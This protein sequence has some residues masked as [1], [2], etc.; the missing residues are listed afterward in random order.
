MFSFLLFLIYLDFKYLLNYIKKE[1][2]HNDDV[3]Y[4]LKTNI[5]FIL[6]LFSY[7]NIVFYL[8]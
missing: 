6:L 5:Y 4:K 8:K 7:I 1:K 2:K 3:N